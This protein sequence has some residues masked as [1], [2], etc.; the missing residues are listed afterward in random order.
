MK[1]LVGLRP[2]SVGEGN[3][4]GIATYIILME[5]SLCGLTVGP[6]LSTTFRKQLCKQAEETTSCTVIKS[7]RSTSSK[8]LRK[9]YFC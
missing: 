2:S 6:F 8:F 9:F 7:L 3:V 5:K 1:I 4:R